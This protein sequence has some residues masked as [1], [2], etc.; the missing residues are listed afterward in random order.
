MDPTALWDASALMTLAFSTSA[1]SYFV[2]SGALA[3]HGWTTV[4]ARELV[5]LRSGRPPHPLA[6]RAHLIGTS[7]LGRPL[8]ETPDETAAVET[9]RATIA[10]GLGH[11]AEHLGE[12]QA[13]VIAR[14]LGAAVVTDDSGAWEEAQ[15]HKV[16]AASVLGLIGIHVNKGLLTPEAGAAMA[17]TLRGPAPH[18]LALD[19]LRLLGRLRM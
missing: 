4:V 17:M 9:L 11:R 12:A 18:S 19:E 14:R 2:G 1:R 5:R 3:R 15:A 7:R 10:A 16:R 6:G 8:A 13:I